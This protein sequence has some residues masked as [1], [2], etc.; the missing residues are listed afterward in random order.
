VDKDW[1]YGIVSS[2]FPGF[3]FNALAG[4]DDINNQDVSSN[5]AGFALNARPS[6]TMFHNRDDSPSRPP[7]K[8][9][10]APHPS[11]RTPWIS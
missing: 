10:E 6:Q 4:P 11:H 8:H 9:Q 5:F 3:T 7:H 2:N 1:F